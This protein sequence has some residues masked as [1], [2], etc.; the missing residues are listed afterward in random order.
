MKYLPLIIQ[1]AGTT[2]LVGAFFQLGAF[3]G[4]LSAGIGLLA[5]GLAAERGKD[6]Q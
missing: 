6:A 1:V 2:L 3:F 5:F 4:T